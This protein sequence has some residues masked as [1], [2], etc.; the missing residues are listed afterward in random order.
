MIRRDVAPAVGHEDDF[1]DSAGTH[2]EL[3]RLF[4]QLTEL[5]TL[6]QEKVIAELRLQ[7][8]QSARS[9]SVPSHGHV[10]LCIVSCEVLSSVSACALLRIAS[11]CSMSFCNM[12]WFLHSPRLFVCLSAHSSTL[13]CRATSCPR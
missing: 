11:L 10:H 6:D 3:L 1:L 5:L 7:N 2:P 9:Y 13:I 4:L 12:S 8:A